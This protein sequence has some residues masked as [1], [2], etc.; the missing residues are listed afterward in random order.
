MSQGGNISSLKGNVASDG[1]GGSGGGGGGTLGGGVSWALQTL[2]DFASP[3]GRKSHQIRKPAVALE[4]SVEK[5][6]GV[7]THSSSQVHD[8]SQGALETGLA[9]TH[10]IFFHFAFLFTEDY[11][12]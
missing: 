10:T 6:H 4:R 5:E 3:S 12:S 8:I 1:G 2:A 11:F 9:L 7:R